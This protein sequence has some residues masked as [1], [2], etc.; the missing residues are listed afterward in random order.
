MHSAMLDKEGAQKMNV[1]TDGGGS[2]IEQLTA[3]SGGISTGP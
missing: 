1:M 2:W 3:P